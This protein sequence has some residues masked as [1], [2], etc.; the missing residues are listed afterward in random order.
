M[1]CA[2]FVASENGVRIASDLRI[3]LTG[4]AVDIFVKNGRELPIDMSDDECE[5]VIR[6]DRL[7]G[8]V[9]ESFARYDA[10]IF[11][12]AL[13]IAVR[14]IAPH[15]KSKLTDPAVIAVDEDGSHAISVLSGHVG[16]AN[17]LT[18]RVADVLECEPV[19]T[20]A[21][22]VNEKIAPDSIAPMM[23]LR[24][25]P[26]PM[27]EVI[28]GAMLEGRD[29]EW[30]IDNRVKRFDFYSGKLSFYGIDAK[31]INA[32]DY[33]MMGALDEPSVLI[34]EDENFRRD[35]LL[36]L[37]PR[38]LIAGIGC[39]QGVP[40]EHIH[41]VL[42]DALDDIGQDLDAVS[43]I[44]STSAKKNERGLLELAR[45]LGVE[46]KFFDNDIMQEKI[47][48]Y[49]LK[50]SEFVKKQIGVGNVCEAA[51]LCAAPNGGRWAMTKTKFEKVTVALLW[52]K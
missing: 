19:I 4:D 44:A 2:V 28:N 34:T 39:R 30:Y 24:P 46:A 1:R 20:T 17:A 11:V 49:K 36:S 6:Y 29:V 47:D 38:R 41:G 37:V 27:I 7:G 18:M 15:L 3:G 51:A 26:K 43:L 33:F 14:M 31:T 9:S 16:G 25:S 12:M 35:N 50:E 52:E 42:S 22:D 5:S 21:T 8:A 23:G 45:L 48:E 40:M 10:L 13:G 32:V